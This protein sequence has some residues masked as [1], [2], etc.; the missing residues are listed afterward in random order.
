MGIYIWDVEGVGP[1]CK[2]VVSLGVSWLSSFVLFVTGLYKVTNKFDRLRG[3]RLLSW[4]RIYCSGIYWLMQSC[5]SSG[6]RLKIHLDVGMVKY[7]LE[8]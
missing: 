7:Y 4:T 2:E 1:A 6:G 5:F 8:R 3:K